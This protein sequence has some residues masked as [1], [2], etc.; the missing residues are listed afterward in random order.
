MLAE[1]RRL[2]ETLRFSVNPPVRKSGV[3]FVKP[4]ESFT[5]IL[6]GSSGQ[7]AVTNQSRLVDPP[8]GTCPGMNS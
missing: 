5:D 6:L 3:S 2:Q 1:V 4:A 7:I 8:P